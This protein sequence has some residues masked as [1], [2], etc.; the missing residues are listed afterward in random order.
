MTDTSTTAA[1]DCHAHVSPNAYLERLTHYAAREES[2]RSTSEWYSKTFRA[3]LPAACSGFMF[4][5]IAE[6]LPDMNAAGVNIQVISPGSSLVYPSQVQQVREELVTAWNDAVHEQVAA[7]PDRFRVLSGLPLPDVPGSLREIE[8]EAHRE[9]SVGFCISSHIHGRGIDDEA[10]APVFQR[11][12]ELGSVVF[13]HPAGFRVEGLLERAVNVDI[14]TQF[15]DALTVVSL[16]SGM[17][18]R[19]PEIRWIVAHLGGAFP[20]LAE[21]LD[22]HWERDRAHSPLLHAPSR[23]LDGVHFE[24]AGHGPRA[25]EYAVGTYGVDRLLFGTDFPMVM[26]DQYSE[27]VHRSIAA[28]GNADS[29]STVVSDNARSLFGL[30]YP[31]TCND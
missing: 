13:V 15:D 30:P 24:T 14:G 27:L 9:A 11:L 29:Q 1:I 28:I 4:G 12:N 10:W 26:A 16:Y 19:Y 6:R 23:S 25:I 31:S 3:K 5:D 18:A 20:Y 22:E 21:R 17:T 8:R 7:S 2:L